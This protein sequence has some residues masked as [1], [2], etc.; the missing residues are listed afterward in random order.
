LWTSPACGFR[1]WATTEL[2]IFRLLFKVRGDLRALRISKN[3]AVSV[4][5]V[6]NSL[7]EGIIFTGQLMDSR[8]LQS[9]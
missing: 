2:E 3:A 9:I 7:A 1:G 4:G 6:Y 5:R 8:D